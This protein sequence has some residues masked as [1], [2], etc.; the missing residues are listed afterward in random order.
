MNMIFINIFSTP[1][2][3]WELDGPMAISRVERAG[4]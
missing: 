2:W 1:Q 3:D 4:D